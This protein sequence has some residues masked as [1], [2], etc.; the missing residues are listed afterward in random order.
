MGPQRRLN[1]QSDHI[2]GIVKTPLTLLLAI[3]L[4]YVYPMITNQ[5]ETDCA[6]LQFAFYKT[7]E[8]FT[9]RKCVYVVEDPLFSESLNQ[10]L[11]DSVGRMAAV[12][13]LPLK[14]GVRKLRPA[15]ENTW[16]I[17]ATSAREAP[18]MLEIS[19]M[20]VGRRIKWP[21]ASFWVRRRNIEWAIS[22]CLSSNAWKVS[23]ACR[24]RERPIPPTSS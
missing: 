11:V 22:F 9:V 16:T 17:S 15:F 20:A 14:S 1:F 6:L 19:S 5:H 8:I 4:T 24:D 12:S 18:L 2:G 3:S 7:P 21:D 10:T 13:V 23:S